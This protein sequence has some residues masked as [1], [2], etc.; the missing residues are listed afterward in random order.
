M[1]DPNPTPGLF[2]E[3]PVDHGLPTR[4]LAIAAVAVLILVAVLVMLA[5]RPAPPAR[6]NAGYA[7]QIEL[8]GVQMSEADSQSGGKLIYLDGHLVN[9]G[10]ATVTGLRVQ[11]DFANDLGQPPQSET[12]PVNLIYMREPYIDTRPIAAA[13]LGPGASADF[14]LIF[15][16]IKDAW[17]QQLPHFKV[18]QVTTR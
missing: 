3:P 8:S 14:R 2:A 10:T 11:V 5:R 9:H 17:N 7:S 12:V 1:S 6:N 15:D 13:P 16:D 4:A 18:T